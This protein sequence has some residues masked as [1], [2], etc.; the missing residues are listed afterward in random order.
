MKSKRKYLSI[1]L[2]LISKKSWRKHFSF[3][4]LNFFRE[5]TN[6]P[7]VEFPYNITR[8]SVIQET[9][10]LQVQDK[11]CFWTTIKI[12]SYCIHL[13]SEIIKKIMQLFYKKK[14]IKVNKTAH[15][16]GIMFKFLSHLYYFYGKWWSIKIFP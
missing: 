1:A 7:N 12:L 4:F 13:L 3:S 14:L 2:C 6:R 8:E 16:V 9:L 10:S 15:F 11:L 5:E